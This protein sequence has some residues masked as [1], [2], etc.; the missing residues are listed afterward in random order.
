MLEFVAE[1]ALAFGDL[2]QL[3]AMHPQI[4]VLKKLVSLGL[5]RPLDR[6]GVAA[7]QPRSEKQQ[8]TIPRNTFNFYFSEENLTPEGF[9]DPKMQDTLQGVAEHFGL[10]LT[11]RLLP[12]DGWLQAVAREAIYA[13]TQKASPADCGVDL[14]KLCASPNAGPLCCLSAAA[15]AKML[16]LGVPASLIAN[17]GKTKLSLAEFQRDFRVLLDADSFLGE[18]LLCLAEALRGLEADEVKLLVEMLA[19]CEC[20]DRET[21]DALVA[22]AAVLR[23]H[24]EAPIAEAV[25]KAAEN[26]WRLGLRAR[27]AALLD[28]LAAESELPAPSYGTYQA[29]SD[30]STGGFHGGPADAVPESIPVA[31]PRLALEGYCPVTLVEKREWRIGDP[32]FSVVHEGQRYFFATAVERL[33]FAKSPGRFAVCFLGYDAVEFVD[34]ERVTSGK[35]EHGAF[36][37]GKIWLF[38]SEASRRKFEQNP[39]V[40]ISAEFAAP[41]AKEGGDAKLIEPSKPTHREA[42][43]KVVVDGPFAKPTPTDKFVQ[44]GAY[45]AGSSEAAESKAVELTLPSECGYREFPPVDPSDGPA[46]KAERGQSAAGSRRLLHGVAG[47]TAEVAARRGSL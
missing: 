30:D 2:E 37:D 31:T 38:E 34:H 21:L 25:A 40:Y 6:L 20:L 16:P 45:D 18:Y 44:R 15:A 26:L 22:V 14:T 32:D 28:A 42:F 27:V 10:R 8:F 17:L 5:L 43:P 47:R 9:F 35:R 41:V 7:C 11:R 29:A 4:R 3:T 23:Q 1:E 36:C 39:K 46:P 13:Q 19:S 12:A 24:R 33:K